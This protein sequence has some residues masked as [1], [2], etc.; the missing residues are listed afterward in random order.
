MSG[1]VIALLD[2]RYRD[3]NP[4]IDIDADEIDYPPEATIGDQWLREPWKVS[5]KILPSRRPLRFVDLH[6][7]I[8]ELAYQLFVR[9]GGRHGHDLDH[10]LEAETLIRSHLTSGA[11]Q[12]GERADGEEPQ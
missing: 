10:W 12:T 9:Q 3:M 11:I 2:G 6:R 7:R 1:I 8:A 4:E 5:P